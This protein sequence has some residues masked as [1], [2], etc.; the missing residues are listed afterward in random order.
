[1][2]MMVKC[3]ISYLHNGM[4]LED[5]KIKEKFENSRSELLRTHIDFLIQKRTEA[6]ARGDKIGDVFFK[7]MSNAFYE[8][9]VENIYD[10]QNIDLVKYF[11]G[12]LELVENSSFKYAV[13]I[14]E[15]LSSVHPVRDNVKFDKFRCIRFLFLEKA[16]LFLYKN[17]YDYF[18]KTIRL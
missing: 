7:L 12:C 9:T 4:K 11:A 15:D 13:D 18:D 17:I 6:K 8:K 10:R 3:Q 2:L 5:I 16:K 1:M 14:H